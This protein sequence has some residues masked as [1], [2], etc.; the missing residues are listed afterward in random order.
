MTSKTKYRW[1]GGT[2]LRS[3]KAQ[4]IGEEL[5]GSGPTT[6]GACPIRTCLRQR[7]IKSRHFTAGSNGTM[8]WLLENIDCNRPAC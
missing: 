1:A 6:T 7:G 8:A 2:G 3:V 5:E 4:V